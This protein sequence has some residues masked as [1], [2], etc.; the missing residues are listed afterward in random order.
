MKCAKCK[1]ELSRKNMWTAEGLTYCLG[2]GTEIDDSNPPKQSEDLMDRGV[3]ISLED[4]GGVEIYDPSTKTR[5]KTYYLK[6]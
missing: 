4:L 5:A 3:G 1:K 2:C 6:R